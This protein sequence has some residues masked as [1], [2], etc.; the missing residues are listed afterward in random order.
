MLLLWAVQ[1]E[2]LSFS[3]IRQPSGRRWLGDSCYVFQESKASTEEKLRETAWAGDGGTWLNSR[4]GEV[5]LSP[6]KK[7][8]PGREDCTDK[9][10]EGD[11]LAVQNGRDLKGMSRT[12]GRGRD[13]VHGSRR[14]HRKDFMSMAKAI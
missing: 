1:K 9:G 5:L 11:V 2:S 13:G 8:S 14:R 10:L 4:P 3:F 6:R 7:R 12:G